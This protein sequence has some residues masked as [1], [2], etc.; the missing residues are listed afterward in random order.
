M[1]S[2]NSKNRKEQRQKSAQKRES[3]YRN[4][5]EQLEHLNKH[6]LV[7]KK[8]RLKLMHVIDNIE[9]KQNKRKGNFKND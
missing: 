7:A 4:A 2:F 1:T 9:R 3:E 6:N 5:K 8:E